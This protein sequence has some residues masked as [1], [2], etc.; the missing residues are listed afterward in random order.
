MSAN[1]LFFL[2]DNREDFYYISTLIA[3]LLKIKSKGGFNEGDS[4]T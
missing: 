1:I 2:L 3:N 4:F